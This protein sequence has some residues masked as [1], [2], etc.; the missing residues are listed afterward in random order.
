MQF[1]K[2][3]FIQ[4]TIIGT[5]MYVLVLHTHW[6]Q[7]LLGLIVTSWQC[8]TFWKNLMKQFG[9]TFI[10]PLISCLDIK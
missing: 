9:E 3:F 8:I 6:T 7:Y 5:S 1:F 4:Y 2:L 10:N